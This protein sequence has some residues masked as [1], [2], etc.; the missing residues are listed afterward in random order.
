MGSALLMIL[1]Q[2]LAKTY[3]VVME[4][5][6]RAHNSKENGYNLMWHLTKKLCPHFDKTKAA[7]WPVW[8]D[9]SDIYHFEKA[10][11]MHCDL[12]R[13]QGSSYSLKQQSEMFL[14]NL[15]GEQYRGHA[16][17][18]LLSL[19]GEAEQIPV[20][21]QIPALVDRLVTVADDDVLDD[22]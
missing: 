1:D 15:T 3:H 16:G 9:G 20:H 21:Y 17:S 14:Q 18:L 7:P 4:M 12:T 8:D 19:T 10:V 5:L 22:M 2:I 11:Q 13:H 6:K